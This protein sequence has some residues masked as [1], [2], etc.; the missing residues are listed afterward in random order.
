MITLKVELDILP[1]TSMVS[2]QVLLLIANLILIFFSLNV[3][4]NWFI[5]RGKTHLSCT[6]VAEEIKLI[7]KPLEIIII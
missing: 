3:L 5:L 1:N 2:H 4:S 6:S 7:F